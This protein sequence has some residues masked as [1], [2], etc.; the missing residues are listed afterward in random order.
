M[1]R[2][3]EYGYDALT[4][5]ASFRYSVNDSYHFEEKITFQQPKSAYDEAAFQRALFLA[6]LV[7][8]T[9][10]FK[11]FPARSVTF[12]SGAIDRWQ[13]HF[14][15]T[16]YQEGL[17]QFAYENHLT[18][19][20]LAHFTATTE[21]SDASV[22]YGGE[23]SIAL[24]SGGKDS[25]LMA[26][27]LQEHGLSFS[28]LYVTS[29]EAHPRL[30]DE[31]SSDELLIVHREIDHEHLKRAHDNGGLSGHVPVTY[32]VLAIATLQAILSNKKT[33][34][35]SIGH[36]G[37]EPHAWIDDLPVTHQWSKTWHAEQL[38]A[39][40]VSRY[41]SPD[42]QVGSPLRSLNE[43]T[44]S[45]L[46]AEKAW[47]RFGDT[48]SSCNQANYTQGHNNTRLSWCGACPKCAN[49]FMLFAPFIEHE[50]LISLFAG[51]D[52]FVDPALQKIFK[53]LLGI[54]DVMKPFECV[55]ERD[56]L[57]YAYHLSGA[58][59]YARL[60]FD[61]P[62]PV[63]DTTIRYASQDWASPYARVTSDIVEP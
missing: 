55:G 52:L 41:V 38:F 17:S 11:T 59:G 46:F 26:G 57:R 56:E 37:E 32:I 51:Q 7:I 35:A 39:E 53:G 48:F 54:D 47:K 61:V 14:L 4:G 21:Q 42:M 2:F 5:I 6:F 36:E 16:V 9:S 60:P 62:V 34:I 63:F 31:I 13:A 22:C 12:Q 19:K 28:S 45:R 1:F 25:L 30:L 15:N 8:G 43:L 20:D 44:I 23:G 33:V 27:L 10:Y 58:K 18:R 29:G 3:D 24:Q 40:Y 50:A 49:A